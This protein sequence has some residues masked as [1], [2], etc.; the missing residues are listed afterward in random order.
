MSTENKGQEMI[1]GVASAMREFK[2]AAESQILAL[3][4]EFEA[5]TGLVVDDVHIGGRDVEF[6]GRTGCLYGLELR[7]VLK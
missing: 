6:A 1:L 3:I 4:Q 5:R 7:V 2:E